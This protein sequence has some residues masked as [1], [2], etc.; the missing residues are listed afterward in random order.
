MTDGRPDPDALLRRV[1]DE[2]R[3][4][5]RGRLTIFFGAAP[6]V[7]KTFAMLM[8]A[9]S[10]RDVERIDVVAGI[11]ETHGR[12]ETTTLLAG[13]ERLPKKNVTYRGTTLQ[14]FDLDAALG[15]KPK[16]LLV[17]E[18]AHTNTEGSRHPKRWQ[19][20]E[21]LLDA[22]IDVFTTL[23]VQ[24]VESLNDMVARITGILVRETVPDSVLD[25]AD[26]IK[27]VDL[28]PDALLER[29][30]EGKVY[31]GAQAERAIENFFRK[32]NL[33][34]LRELALRKTAERVDAEMQAYRRAHGIEKT[35]AISD[36]LLVCTSPSPYSA[37]LLR[38]A[39]RMAAGLHAHWFA[40]NVETPAT[41]RLP[42]VDRDRISHNL[43][44]AEQLG[45]EVVTLT[46]ERAADEIL[47]FSR[48][49]NVTKI[50]VGKPRARTWLDR[51]RA[52]FVDRLVLE[53]GDIDVFVT[54][55]DPG[56]AEPARPRPRPSARDT[57]G[58]LAAAA[59][60]AVASILAGAVFGRE[61]LADVVMVYLLGI[62]LV[63]MRFGFRASL[64]T[65]VLSV[66]SFDFFFVPPFFSIKVSDFRHVITFGVMLLVAVVISGLTQR[67][68]DQAEV[69]SEGERRT[70]VL[71]AMSRELAR[72][73]GRDALVRVAATH[74]EEVFASGVVVFVASAS[75]D[76][77]ETYRSEGLELGSDE[78]PGLAQWVWIHQREAGLGTDTLP[79]GRAIYV[80]LA[81]GAI[82]S[83]VGV[84]ALFPKDLARFDDPEQRR[85]VDAFADQTAMAIE[86][87]RLAEEM[88]RARIQVEAEQLRS[89]LLSSVSHDLRTPLAV[90]TGAASSL[91]D[92]DA[93]LPPAT[94]RE[95]SQAILEEAER[96]N[97]LV[98]NLLDM[99]RI[100]SGAVKVK[101]EW[102]SV[103]EVVGVALNRTEPRLAQRRVAT[104]VPGDLLA[105]FD[106][107]LVEQVLVNL[108]ENA[109]KYAEG[110][111]P[112]EVNAARADTE[113]VIEVADRGPGISSGDRERVFEKFYR[114]K[115]A[116]GTSGV[117][118]GL[119]ICR[120]IV[121][122]HGGRIWV[123]DRDGGGSSFKLAL[124]LDARPPPSALPEIPAPGA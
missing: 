78:K 117:G 107:V 40:V 42:Q 26:E 24:H 95:L 59:A 67:V 62:V 30:R 50:L 100:E 5:R 35:W 45:A 122:A 105:P 116:P 23:N 53:S 12:F 118:L 6:G 88:Q 111:T 1:Q 97:R 120:A 29:L 46:G 41:R 93:T 10:L 81:V 20:V 22:G 75:G 19:D 80:P 52:S 69:A 9:D 83:L 13:F 18:L 56:T 86:R 124:P 115:S 57:K 101:K 121:V 64:L 71:Y 49:R 110:N 33:I 113:V 68:R 82:R 103:E 63:S 55:G 99:T 27:L 66:L 108:L 43:R 106:A 123:E 37:N 17:D 74:I 48:E 4:Q 90:M 11:V 14:E 76:L 47:R 60:T 96:L 16:L 91:V 85:L 54:S 25:A 36:R 98:R 2:E 7:G 79:G 65:A 51:L 112:I 84:L 58:Y 109:G 92:D 44:L 21:E 39:R 32:E 70:G 114:G 104:K 34:A 72:T 38:V 87:G 102:Q 15:R 31:F 73:Q 61:R 89:T 8:E 3:K 28:P 119:A 77:S 94:R